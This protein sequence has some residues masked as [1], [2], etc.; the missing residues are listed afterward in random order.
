MANTYSQIHLQFVFAVKHRDSLIRNNWKEELYLY[1]S[2]IIEKQGHK[3]LAING[4]PDHIH[5]F[6]GMRPNQ[7]VSDLLQDIKRN[8]SLW[9]NQKGFVNGKFEWQEGYGA[10]SYG[11]SQVKA[12][13]DYIENQENHHKKISFREEYIDFLQKFEIEYDERYIFNEIN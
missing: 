7:S 6:I 3:L 11:K 2:G 10:F 12:V 9:I 1:I 8:S 5:I 13:I 4:M